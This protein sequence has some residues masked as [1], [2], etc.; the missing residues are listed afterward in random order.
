V[1]RCTSAHVDLDATR[2]NFQA[3]AEYL[4]AEAALNRTAS[5]GP[6]QPPGIIAVVKANAY[7]HGA[8]RVARAL[9]EAGA[10]WLAVADIEEGL[11]LRESG[12]RAR[13]LVFGALSVSELG[14]VFSHELT[15]SVASP[16]A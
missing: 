12:S 2:H 3:I 13:I 5:K 1:I 15:P 4:S 9:E 14:G 11:E 16:A 10:K 8:V 6:S 7:G